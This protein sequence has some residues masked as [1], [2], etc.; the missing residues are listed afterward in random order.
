MLVF[1]Y[2]FKYWPTLVMNQGSA[3]QLMVYDMQRLV[4]NIFWVPDFSK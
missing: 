1:K 4:S 2:V 3:Y